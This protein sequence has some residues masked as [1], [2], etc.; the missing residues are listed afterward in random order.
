[1]CRTGWIGSSPSA[2]K[3]DIL[4]E[5]GIVDNYSKNGIESM[6]EKRY[7]TFNEQL[8]DRFGGK[9]FKVSLDAGFTCPNRDGTLGTSGCVY[10]SERGS[11]DFAG[12]KRAA[13]SDQFM[14]SWCQAPVFVFWLSCRL[15]TSCAQPLIWGTDKLVSGTEV[16]QP[17]LVDYMR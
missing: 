2:A 3:F 1:M 6:Q 4:D 17:S 14:I 8:R 15:R 7:H 5:V 12:D 13:I 9:I 16:L 11:G 10:C